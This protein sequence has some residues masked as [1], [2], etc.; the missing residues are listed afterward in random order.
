MRRLQETTKIHQ[1]TQIRD[2]L[3]KKLCTKCGNP[4]GYKVNVSKS[5]ITRSS[6]CKACVPH[7]KKIFSTYEEAKLALP[8]I[9][10][11]RILLNKESI[12]KKQKAEIQLAQDILSRKD[13]SLFTLVR[14]L[15]RKYIITLRIPIETNKP[16]Y[17]KAHT[18]SKSNHS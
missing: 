17:V 8:L 1:L 4:T 10:P 3:K 12:G 5:L 14:R 2:R 11:A 16:I 18:G 15:R 13:I 6:R 9:L 7:S